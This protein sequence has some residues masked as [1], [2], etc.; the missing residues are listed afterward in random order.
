MTI[1]QKGHYFRVKMLGKINFIVDKWQDE[2]TGKY[3][4]ELFKPI[5]IEPMGEL[6][7]VIESEKEL[8]TD[9]DVLSIEKIAY[10]Y[11]DLID[12]NDIIKVY[13]DDIMYIGRVK[14]KDNELITYLDGTKYY[15]KDLIQQE[16]IT[17]VT[18]EY[19]AFINSI[20]NNLE[21]EED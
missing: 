11:Y 5:R 9:D 7:D 6:L 18:S 14:R 8:T 10:N 20:N 15:L 2:D 4:Y 17:S 21:C 13:I 19:E 3:C 12:T 1:L 16:A